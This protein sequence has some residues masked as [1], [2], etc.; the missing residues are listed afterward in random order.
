M[1]DASS[2]PD[3]TSQTR[4]SSELWVPAAKR[5]PSGLRA[6]ERTAPLP[7]GTENLRRLLPLTASRISIDPWSPPEA[8]A[9]PSG[10]KA[11]ACIG[12]GISQV[13]TGLN[14]SSAQTRSVRSAETDASRF[15]CLVT[16][17]A[18]TAEECPGTT[19]T[20]DP[21]AAFHR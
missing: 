1:S 16:A 14:G 6:N 15:P 20:L 2:L 13:R 8:I 21:V 9:F 12:S 4:T 5:L 10:L 7:A 3:S 11:T 17:I 19:A 18:L